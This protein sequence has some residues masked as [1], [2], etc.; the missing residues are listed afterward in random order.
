MKNFF[1]IVCKWATAAATAVPPKPHYFVSTSLQS[2]V[3]S[4]LGIFSGLKKKIG[5]YL[6][7]K[8]ITIGLIVLMVITL[9]KTLHIP[10][11]ILNIFGIENTEFLQNIIAGIFGLITRLVSRGII[12]EIFVNKDNYATM[13]GNPPLDDGSGNNPIIGGGAGGSSSGSGSGN[14]SSGSGSSEGDGQKNSPENNK[15]GEGSSVSSGIDKT[16]QEVG[17]SPS[18][19]NSAA[20][21][22]YKAERY[23]KLMSKLSNTLSEDMKNLTLNM[24]KAEDD[25]E[26]KKMNDNRD[27]ILD[28]MNMVNKSSMEETQKILPKDTDS[29]VSKRNYEEVE[30]EKKEEPSKKEKKEEASKK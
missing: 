17:K 8:N 14:S 24:E 15:E 4:G 3:F 30:K 28:M 29:T 9:V 19:D 13:G 5:K 20:W 18:A 21:R 27:N 26:W 7:I 22:K 6:T 23:Q 1:S 16:P 2:S 10:M 12:E 11:Y 25:A